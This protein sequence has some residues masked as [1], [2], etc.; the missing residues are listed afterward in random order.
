MCVCL[1]SA[2]L[3]KRLIGFFMGVLICSSSSAGRV[4]MHRREM[5]T[6]VR[7]FSRRLLDTSCLL[8]WV[9]LLEAPVAL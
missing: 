9:M 7:G 1:C 4:V 8:S 3:V 6:L 2:S 5:I